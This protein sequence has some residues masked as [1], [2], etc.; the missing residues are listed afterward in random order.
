MR[1]T[2][3]RTT[4]PSR[5]DRSRTAA[6]GSSGSWWK[7]CWYA[8]SRYSAAS[9][10]PPVATTAHQRWVRKVPRRTRNSPTNPFRPGRPLQA[11]QPG[12]VPGAAALV[13]PADHDEEHGDDE[14]VV[15]HLQDPA[16]DALGG[17]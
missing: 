16:G 17:E 13:D 8:H 9:T 14:P 6:L 15:D 5:H 1:S 4:S 12:G 3:G 11:A 2:R 7:A 10:T